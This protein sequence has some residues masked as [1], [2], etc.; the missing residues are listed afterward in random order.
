M[1][2]TG[3]DMILSPKSDI[4]YSPMKIESFFFP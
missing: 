1:T 4:Y 2:K 3:S